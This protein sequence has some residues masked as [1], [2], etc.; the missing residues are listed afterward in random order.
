MVRAKQGS[1]AFA[2]LMI[3]LS[4]AYLVNECFTSPRSQR[5]SKTSRA[6]HVRIILCHRL[7]IDQTLKKMRSA[8]F[9][10][11][12]YNNIH[13]KTKQDQTKVNNK[14]VKDKRK[15]I[16]SIMKEID[17]EDFYKQILKYE[18]EIIKIFLKIQLFT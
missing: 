2:F 17:D 10:Q 7:V 5:K 13:K 16:F 15:I 14:V 4:F 12:L 18:R 1:L 6:S 11:K 3:C 8:N 9:D